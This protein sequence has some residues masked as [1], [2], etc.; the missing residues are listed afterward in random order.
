M[1]SSSS[2]GSRCTPPAR[3]AALVRSR[4]ARSMQCLRTVQYRAVRGGGSG[5][6]GTVG[7]SGER[8]DAR[9]GGE[10]GGHSWSLR[11]VIA[12]RPRLLPSAAGPGDR[13]SLGHPSWR[14]RTLV[15]VDAV[16][17]ALRART[18]ARR[19]SRRIADATSAI[20]VAVSPS[21]GVP[22]DT[23]A[24]LDPPAQRPTATARCA[25][26]RHSRGARAC[27]RASR[28]RVGVSDP[29]HGKVRHLNSGTSRHASRVAPRLPMLAPITTRAALTRSP[30][31]IPEEVQ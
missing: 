15:H 16:S 26:R 18:G 21:D 14:G 6:G 19:G 12:S 29:P 27:T 4:T 20:T 1:P 7:G 13:A 23:P 8:R 31:S 5:P 9:S 17:V 30:E 24:P 11:V 2:V 25:G 3:S 22:R 28:H 10:R